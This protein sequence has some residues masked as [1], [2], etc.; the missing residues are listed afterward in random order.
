M[1]LGPSVEKPP[2][3]HSFARSLAPTG[4]LPTGR[5][6]QGRVGLPTACGSYMPSRDCPTSPC[7]KP[8][9]RMH[10]R[11]GGSD[12]SA[13][14]AAPHPIEADGSLP[15]CNIKTSFPRVKRG[16]PSPSRCCPFGR[17]GA[18]FERKLPKGPR[19][20]VSIRVTWTACGEEGRK[21]GKEKKRTVFLKSNL[22]L[23]KLSVFHSPGVAPIWIGSCR[24]TC[25]VHLCVGTR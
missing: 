22:A 8:G 24:Q 18:I 25:R 14:C 5:A 9:T 10:I 1:C 11:L 21:G 17:G 19:E 23:L 20:A 13:G 16:N 7:R 3:V 6:E 12:E 4:Y 2:L 15:R